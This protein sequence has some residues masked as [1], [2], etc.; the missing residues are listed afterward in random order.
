MAWRQVCGHC[1]SQKAK[2]LEVSTS[3][4]RV[5]D[6]C[7]LVLTDINNCPPT[8]RGILDY[9][10]NDFAQALTLRMHYLFCC[11]PFSE[12]VVDFG[13]SKATVNSVHTESN[14]PYLDRFRYE[15]ERV[16]QLLISEIL[17]CGNSQSC[18][19][20]IMHLIEAAEAMWECRSHHCLMLT[21]F[22]LQS[23]AV[24][25]L[26]SS[27]EK[28][29]EVM[30]GRWEI[31]EGKIGMGGSKLAAA[32]IK[33]YGNF[34]TF[35]D[36]AQRVRGNDENSREI[37]SEVAGQG[38]SNVNKADFDQIMR[39]FVP[40]DGDCY[41]WQLYITQL[42]RRTYLSGV[43]KSDFTGSGVQGTSTVKKGNPNPNPNPT[44]AK[45]DDTRPEAKD[46]TET[47]TFVRPMP[48]FPF[49]SGLIRGLVRSNELPDF[50][51][52]VDQSMGVSNELKLISPGFSQSDPY[53]RVLNLG[54]FRSMAALVA[55]LRECQTRPYSF[56]TSTD[57]QTY[58][59]KRAIY[60]SEEAQWAR[61]SDIEERA[62]GQNRLGSNKVGGR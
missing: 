46:I 36:L 19:K 51:K 5:C 23:H 4:V 45:G 35:E 54:K 10:S 62:R 44:D 29:K 7:Y 58:L 6:S 52:Q 42:L 50:I 48:C 33:E 49:L 31:L 61:S 21:Y 57:I 37:S 55:I 38:S 56:A 41:R 26:T 28:V 11:I 1:S 2:V 30:P 25:S 13:F 47:D 16:Q 20:A 34:C 22:A 14:T 43:V 18:A 8:M 24:F 59:Q 3:P 9:S 32:V 60:K 27:W 40:K 39:N 15:T 53:L 17:H 12:F